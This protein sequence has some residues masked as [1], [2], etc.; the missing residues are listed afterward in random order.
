MPAFGSQATTGSS[1]GG[2][3]NAVA[4]D[5][6]DTTRIVLI[7]LGVAL[8]VVVLLPILFMTGM[9]AWM[10]GGQCCGGG[11]PWGAAGLALL[12][13]VVGGSL[14]ALAVQRR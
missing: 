3:G 8:I 5:M 12:I 1:G 4:L 10:M 14:R 7:A 11:A 2:T 6:S 9:M 13:I